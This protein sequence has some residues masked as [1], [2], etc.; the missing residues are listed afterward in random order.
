MRRSLQMALKKQEEEKEK[1]EEEQ[2]V[3]VRTPRSQLTLQ[4]Q[5]W[6]EHYQSSA[7]QAGR[8]LAGGLGLLATLQAETLAV[9]ATGGSDD[10]VRGGDTSGCRSQRLC[11]SL[12]PLRSIETEARQSHGVLCND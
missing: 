4:H 3:L 10:S 11:M 12:A 8:T 6:A 2:E 1:V 9:P 5:R 7:A